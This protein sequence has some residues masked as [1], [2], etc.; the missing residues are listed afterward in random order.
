MVFLKRCNSFKTASMTSG[1]RTPDLLK[2]R[3]PMI[4]MYDLDLGRQGLSMES[5]LMF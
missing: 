5:R 4:F 1:V 3:S 2:Y